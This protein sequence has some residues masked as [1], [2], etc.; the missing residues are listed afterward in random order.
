ML[1]KEKKP[2]KKKVANLSEELE[3]LIR[4]RRSPSIRP[5]ELDGEKTLRVLIRA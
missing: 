3:S 1:T 2:G 5:W 4:K